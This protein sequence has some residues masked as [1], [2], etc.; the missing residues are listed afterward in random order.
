M[1]IPTRTLL[2]LH[3]VKIVRGLPIQD[4]VEQALVAY[5]AQSPP[6]TRGA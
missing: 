6:E 2:R 1:R 4:I 5:F 3:E